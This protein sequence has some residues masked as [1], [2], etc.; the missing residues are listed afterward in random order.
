MVVIKLLSDKKEIDTL[1]GK[2]VIGILLLQDIVAIIVL[3]ILVTLNEFSFIVLILSLFKGLIALFVA[4]L[5]SKYIFPPLF[6]FAAKSQEL[7]F[8]SAVAV[9]MLYSII[10][11][12]LG[13]SIV[14]G[15]FVAG[16]SLASLPYNIEIIGRIKPLRDFFSVIFFVSL[17][18]TLLLSTFNLILKPLIILLLIVLIAK[19]L[20][21]MFTTS[22]F[23]YKKRTSF[24]SAMSLAQISEF[25]LIIVSQGLLLGHVNQE[26][27]SLTVLL[28]IITITTTTYFVK[29]ENSIYKRFSN[30]L[31]FF[32][33]FSENSM[34]LEYVP[35][36]KK[37][38]IILCGYDKIG[39][40]IVKTLKKLKKKS[41]SCR[42]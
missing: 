3:S 20:I 12:F 22:F 4:V 41:T 8:I 40:S 39:Y 5:I 21:I 26:I 1:H 7:L 42:L 11:N 19:P 16:I 23:G 32:D 37:P 18:M 36:T 29:F 14:I 38:E 25:S 24:L 28:A 17:G 27:F 35:K 30:Y 10:F 13:F 6:R 2:I 31:T 33:R 34:D 9:S 15:A